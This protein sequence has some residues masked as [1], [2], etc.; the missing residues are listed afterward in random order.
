VQF[1][2]EDID[3]IKWSGKESVTKENWKNGGTK[4]GDSASQHA[5]NMTNYL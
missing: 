1:I 4:A 3:R 2:L 5:D